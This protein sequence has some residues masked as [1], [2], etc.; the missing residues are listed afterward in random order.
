MAI[1]I[2]PMMQRGSKGRLM[3]ARYATNAPVL[4]LAHA[5]HA[6]QYRLFGLVDRTRLDGD[7]SGE[8]VDRDR[9]TLMYRSQ[10]DCAA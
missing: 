4:A 6:A 8:P 9:D 3:Q 1:L 5:R 2:L 7:V 10:N